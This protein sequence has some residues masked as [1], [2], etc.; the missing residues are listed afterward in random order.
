M[1]YAEA[2]KHMVNSQVRTSDVTDLRIQVALETIPREKFLPAELKAQAYVEREI[3]YAPGRQLLT[4]RDFSKLIAAAD[5]GPED[6]VLDVACGS[7]YSTAVLANLA[8]MVVA[9]E[10]SEALAAA[11]QENLSE[12]GV[13][14]AAVVVADPAK[15]AA[16]QGPFD[17][18]F[19]GGVIVREPEALLPQLKEGGRLAAIRRTNGVSRGVIYSRAGDAF[20]ARAVFDA[21]ASAVLPEFQV[22]KTFS[23]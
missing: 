7:G 13:N 3:P 15:A 18:I 9:V 19:I 10:A 16:D 5:I 14:N 17:V 23:F 4:A 22:P 2:R 11:A 12:L 8:E 21:S 6:L 20:A 1:D